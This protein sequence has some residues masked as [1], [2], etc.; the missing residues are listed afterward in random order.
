[1]K[2]TNR[3]LIIGFLLFIGSISLLHVTTEDR[4]FSASENRVLAQFPEFSWDKFLSGKF[5]KEFETYLSDQFVMKDFWTDLKA[6]TEKV[7]LKK[8]NNG[9]YFGR[10]SFLFERFPEPGQ[11][12][13]A[14]IQ[15]LNDFADKLQNT[16]V[17]AMVAPTSIAIYPNKLPKYAYT[18]HQLTAITAIRDQLDKSIH[19]I[20]VYQ[21]LKEAKDQSI[22]YKTDHHWTTNGAFI[23]YQAAAQAM[24]I[25]PYTNDA[26]TIQTV[27]KDFFGT[28]DAKANDFTTK[29]DEIDVFLPKFDVTYS[30][31]F[32]DDTPTMDSLYEWDSLNT[33]DQYALFLN[34]NHGKTIVHS[35]INNGR[36]LLVVKDSYA[37]ALVPF[38]AN[39]FEEIH[40]IDLRY[41][42]EDLAGYMEQEGIQDVLVLYNIATFA[43][44]PNLIWLRQ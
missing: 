41:T 25:E 42:H 14:N 8:E 37:H 21:P 4:A 15:H 16:T 3:L 19:W 36:K 38:L 32:G 39:H 22:Y 12:F 6:A 2:T 29:P 33:R 35:S 5:T 28:Y 11:Q 34:G 17:Y 13:N 30:V 40:L 20:D 23:A 9:I 44:D 43:N 24:G 27:S 10:G 1:M 26:F 18:A 31:E 7:A